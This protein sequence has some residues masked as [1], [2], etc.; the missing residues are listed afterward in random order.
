[1]IHSFPSLLYFDS[2]GCVAIGDV[3]MRELGLNCPHLQTLILTSCHSI[4]GEGIV[5]VGECCKQIRKV[6]V[7]T[8]LLYI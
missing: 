2:I 5:A 7:I 8:V 6:Q 4:V 3:C 1:M